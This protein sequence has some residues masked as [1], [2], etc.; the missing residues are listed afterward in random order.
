MSIKE[1]VC[2]NTIKVKWVNSGVTPTTLV[3]GVYTGSETLVDSASMVSSG[4]GFYYHLHT[5]PNT[6]GY[7]VT[8]TKATISGKPYINRERYLAVLMDVN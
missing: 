3:A 6:P 7:Y 8:E 5:V 2:G 4:N 1:F